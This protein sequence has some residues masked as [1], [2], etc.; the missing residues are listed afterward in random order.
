MTG[1]L[2]EASALEALTAVVASSVWME[3]PDMLRA[4]LDA[5]DQYHR[6]VRALRRTSGMTRA[7]LTAEIRR[8]LPIPVVTAERVR[9]VMAGGANRV[10]AAKAAGIGRYRG[11]QPTA[12]DMAP[13]VLVMHATGA[14]VSDIVLA[15]GISRAS[16]YRI[17]K[18]E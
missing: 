18:G 6:D 8:R 13:N 1:D 2:G 14:T 17:L 16:V 9:E 3:R 4:L 10:Q 12:Q 7:A 5:I 15:L 11:R